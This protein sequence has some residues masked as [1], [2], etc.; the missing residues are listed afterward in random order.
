MRNLKF[1]LKN[2]KGSKN[3]KEVIKIVVTIIFALKC[4]ILFSYLSFMWL[5]MYFSIYNIF[6]IVFSH[7]DGSTHFHHND[8]FA[9]CWI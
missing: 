4:Y 7:V 3:L 6:L 1:G 5:F 9:N 2:H 8:N